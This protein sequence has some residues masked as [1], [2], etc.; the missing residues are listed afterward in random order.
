MTKKAKSWLGVSLILLIALITTA[1]KLPYGDINELYQKKHNRD[2]YV[3]RNVEAAL[4]VLVDVEDEELLSKEELNAFLEKWNGGT[5][6]GYYDTM[7][8]SLRELSERFVERME[9]RYEG[10][11]FSNSLVHAEITELP[12]GLFL[13]CLG[14]SVGSYY[15][16]YYYE[17]SAFLYKKANLSVLREPLSVVKSRTDNVTKLPS[18]WKYILD[19]DYYRICYD[20]DM[21]TLYM[22]NIIASDNT[23]KKQI[24]TA[25]FDEYMEDIKSMRPGTDRPGSNLS[26][27]RIEKYFAAKRKAEAKVANG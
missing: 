21:V 25:D 17:D 23:V 13:I 8:D 12:S 3:P 11:Q 1:A 4:I 6:D 18:E 20:S 5:F 10:Y 19:S 27:A 2:T 22:P 26:L 14:T 16:S 15:S 24:P 7:P 9:V